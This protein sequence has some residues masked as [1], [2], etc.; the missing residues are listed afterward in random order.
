MPKLLVFWWISE[1]C[2]V[3][4][5]FLM[6]MFWGYFYYLIW[7]LYTRSCVSQNNI[8]RFFEKVVKFDLQ[9]PLKIVLFLA[10]F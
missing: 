1:V 10:F 3:T 6:L 4:R 9:S 8:P 7:V 2:V 5:I